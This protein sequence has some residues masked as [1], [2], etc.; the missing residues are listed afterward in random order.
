MGY[1]LVL[2]DFFIS[3]VIFFGFGV[4]EK[5]QENDSGEVKEITPFGKNNISLSL[6]YNGD[7]IFGGLMGSSDMTLFKTD[8]GGED[9]TELQVDNIS[10]EAYIGIRL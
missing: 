2:N 3:G 4:M 5:I 1:T 9:S 7:F 10:V 8:I 6:G